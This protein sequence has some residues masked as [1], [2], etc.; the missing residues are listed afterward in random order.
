MPRGPEDGYERHAQAR[1]VARGCCLAADRDA[2]AESARAPAPDHGTER[3]KNQSNEHQVEDR[4][5]RELLYIAKLTYVNG[6]A[7]PANGV[8][9][10]GA[11]QV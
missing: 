1:R 6:V 10:E 8:T 3:G 2:A 4:H 11:R 5:Y 7:Q 9:V